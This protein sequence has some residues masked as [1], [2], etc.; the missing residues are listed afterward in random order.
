MH[1]HPKT[2]QHLSQYVK[3]C[4]SFTWQCTLSLFHALDLKRNRKHCR[5]R[6]IKVGMC[7]GLKCLCSGD[8][9]LLPLCVLNQSPLLASQVYS[10]FFPLEKIPFLLCHIS[11]TLTNSRPASNCLSAD[12][13][14]CL[15]C[16]LPATVLSSKITIHSG[17]LAAGESLC[18]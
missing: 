10:N 13:I 5:R 15:G 1:S 8:W 3:C 7:G 11:K 16:K 9:S 18:L 2:S 17:I 14:C 4:F 12:Q 6:R